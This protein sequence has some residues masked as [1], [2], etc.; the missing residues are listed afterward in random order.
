MKDSYMLVLELWPEAP[1]SALVHI[2]RPVE[3]L[4]GSRGQGVLSL[5]LSLTTAHQ[6]S[7]RKELTNSPKAPIFV[8]VTQGTPPDPLAAS[9]A[10][11]CSPTVCICFKSCSPKGWLSVSLSLG[12]DWVPPVQDTH[13]SWHIL[14]YWELRQSWII[15]FIFYTRPLLPGWERWLF[16]LTYRTLHRDSS[17][18][19]DMFQTEQDKPQGKKSLMKQMLFTW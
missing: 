5:P 4:S 2:W 19:R 6:L 7:P 13:R 18:M 8:T 11:I 16:H 17:K 3:G 9:W 1:L 10:Y 14:N 15:R 12:A